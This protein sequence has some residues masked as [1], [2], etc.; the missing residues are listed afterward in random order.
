MPGIHDSVVVGGI[1]L[2][3]TGPAMAGGPVGIDHPI[4][5]TDSGLWSRPYTRDLEY[6]VV[7][8]GLGGALWLGGE[9]ES[10]KT[11]W[12]TLDAMIGGQIAAQGAK[13]VFGRKRPS[14]T[15]DPN[16]WF[17]G[18]HAQSF[19]SGEVTLQASFVTPFIYTYA[20][21]NPWIWALEALPAYDAAARVKEGAHWQ[22]DVLAG[23]ALG[24]AI[25]YVAATRQS[26]IFLSVLP[27]GFM[28]GVQS[29]F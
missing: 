24:S 10:G 29:R 28:I 14:Q 4:A 27:H 15:S 17:K 1:V 18:L 3:L 13:Y 12:Q 22:S 25:G 7:A 16:Q 20:Q 11:C 6:A 21:R 5:P 9:S 8:A 2:A 26:P 23:W 19:P